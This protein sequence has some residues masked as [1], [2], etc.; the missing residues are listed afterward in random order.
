[1]YAEDTRILISGI[2][3]VE[4]GEDKARDKM[5]STDG[6]RIVPCDPPV[7][8]APRAPKKTKYN[9]KAPKRQQ[10]LISGNVGPSAATTNKHPTNA[11]PKYL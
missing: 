3:Q 6:M 4:S 1:V 10:E 7:I 11:Q 2:A 9:P 8:S 5:S